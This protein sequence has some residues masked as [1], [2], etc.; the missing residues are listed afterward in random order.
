[1]PPLPH[2]YQGRDAIGAFLPGREERR[3]TPVRLAPTLAN[4]QPP[5]SVSFPQFD[6]PQALRNERP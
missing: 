4:D 2:A 3:G 6:L 1:M 5:T